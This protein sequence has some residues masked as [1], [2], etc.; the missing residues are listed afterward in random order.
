MSLRGVRAEGSPTVTSALKG[1]V[2]DDQRTRSEFLSLA[3]T[4]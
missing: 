4:N 2:R 1:I 3:W